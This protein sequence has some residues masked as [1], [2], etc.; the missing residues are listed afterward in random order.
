MFNSSEISER[1]SSHFDSV[2]P[3]KVYAIYGDEAYFLG[4]HVIPPFSKHTAT[5]DQLRV[6][7]S[8]S[9]VRSAVEMEFG[10]TVQLFGAVK[11]K[12]NNKV[13]KTKPA[14]KYILA[15][16]FKNIHT[17]IHGSAS[18][19]MFKL[20]PPTLEEYISGLMREQGQNDLMI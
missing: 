10:K 14:L 11:W 9:K 18:S 5:D 4:D 20:Q 2:S 19:R 16:I 15:T 6:N 3:E 13:G 17:C 8:M 12:Y 1:L 7:R